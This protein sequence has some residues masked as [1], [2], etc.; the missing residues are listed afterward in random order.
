MTDVE[1]RY[2]ASLQTHTSHHYPLT[3]RYCSITRYTVTCYL[4]VSLHSD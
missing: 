2:I 4:N 3:E 1:T